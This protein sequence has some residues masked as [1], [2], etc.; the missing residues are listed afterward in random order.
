MVKS[1]HLDVYTIDS[2]DG[3]IEEKMVKPSITSS[4]SGYVS[5]TEYVSPIPGTEGASCISSV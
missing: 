3:S 5:F 4:D 1:R 2:S